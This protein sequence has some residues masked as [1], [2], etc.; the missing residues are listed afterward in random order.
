MSVEKIVHE[1][2]SESVREYLRGLVLTLE[3]LFG[4]D[5]KPRRLALLVNADL[6]DWDIVRE[7]LSGNRLPQWREP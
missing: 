7:D 2:P 1:P 5:W 6:T 3:D 4:L